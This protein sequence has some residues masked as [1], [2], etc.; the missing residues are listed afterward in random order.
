MFKNKYRVVTDNYAGYESQIKYWW[1]PFIWVQV[2]GV[3]T[4][5]KL[6][7]AIKYVENQNKPV[8]YS[9]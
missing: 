2:G 7:Q 1:F 9:D 4:H 6:E 8:W 5:R 3:N